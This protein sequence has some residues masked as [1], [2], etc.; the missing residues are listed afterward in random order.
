MPSSWGPVR[1]QSPNQPL[2]GILW[3]RQGKNLPKMICAKDEALKSL[4]DER[5]RRLRAAT[6]A[7]ATGRKRLT[8]WVGR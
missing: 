2:S 8:R 3:D 1:Q 7:Q 4:M 6:E 5:M